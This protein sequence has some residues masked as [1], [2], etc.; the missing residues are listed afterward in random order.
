VELLTCHHFG[1]SILVTHSLGSLLGL[2]LGVRELGYLHCLCRVMPKESNIIDHDVIGHV[3]LICICLKIH[4]S[5]YFE[6]KMQVLYKEI[7][8]NSN[9][10]EVIQ[11][12]YLACS[13]PKRQGGKG[14]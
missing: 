11:K 5:F 4:F 3:L 1:F 6:L 14:F 2:T 8:R 13:F 7:N 12:N 9:E 10:I